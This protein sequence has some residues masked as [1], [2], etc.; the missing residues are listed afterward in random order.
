MIYA[1]IGSTKTPE[2]VCEVFVELGKKLAFIDILL[3]SGGA[4][5]ADESFEKG[6]DKVK[7]P[8]EIYLPWKGFQNNKSKL[9]VS[10]PKAFEIAKHYHPGWLYLNQG[11]QKLQ[12]R[13]S[14]QVLGWDLKTPCDFVVC[15]TKGG[16]DIG[17][18]SQAIRIA[19]DYGIP[20]FNFGKYDS[21]K[22]AKAAFNDFYD[23]L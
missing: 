23:K 15:W 13:N 14:H 19:R 7:G 20:I 2:D 17:G 3:R 9:I 18:T 8:K 10:D 4:P 22:E 1:G 16:K 6:C 12:A 11:G 5:N 21:I